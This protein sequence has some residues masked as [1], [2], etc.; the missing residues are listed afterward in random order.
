ML[1]DL[2]TVDIS[3]HNL[4]EVPKTKGL[5]DQLIQ[6]FSSF[7]QF[8]FEKL[9]SSSDVGYIDGFK[10]SILT[11][12]LYDQYADF[13]KKI[14]AK[15]ILTPAVFGKNLS[16]YCDVEVKQR[17]NSEQKYSRF[18]FFSDKAICRQQFSK[19]IGMKINWNI[20]QV[21]NIDNEV[22]GI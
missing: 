20:S 14:N 18:Y 2:L 3:K 6:N 16:K 4:R 1:H 13:S 7:E 5:F 9:L 11:T 8:W 12:E 15:Y 19:Q 17:L 21:E 22:D 10:T